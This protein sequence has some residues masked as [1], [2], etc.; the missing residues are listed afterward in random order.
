M[1]RWIVALLTAR[2]IVEARLPPPAYVPVNVSLAA[3]LV[4]LARRSG[5][6]W[7]ELGLARRHAGRSA[8]FG[9]AFS[10]IATAAMAAGAALP[11]LRRVYDDERV[12]VRAG[13]RELAYQTM[14]RIPLG[15]VALEEVAFRGVLLAS[16]S[17]DRL[18]RR[19]VALDS[20]LFGLWHVVPT[21]ETA[22]IN[23]VG[24]ARR[25]GLVAGS[26]VGTAVGGWLFCVLRVRSGHVL[27]PALLHLAINDTGYLLSWWVRSR[28]PS[29][30]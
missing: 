14:L 21:F 3:L 8:R 17:R 26:V 2:N 29:V 28:Q 5:V 16:L 9:V 27:A 25:V 19:A 10:A 23:R 7:D 1:T 18:P 20:V 15:T 13:G 12:N 22:R 6:S 4:G 30:P 24:G 11:R